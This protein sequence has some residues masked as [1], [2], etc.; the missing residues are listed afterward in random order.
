ME[1]VKGDYISVIDLGTGSIRNSIYDFQG[2]VVDYIR[3]DNPVVYPRP[4]WAEQ[5]TALWWKLITE[6]YHKIPET[7]RNNI[8]AITVTSQR[9]GIVAVNQAFEPLDNMIIWLDNRTEQEAQHI[10]ET[11]GRDAIYD[12]CGLIPHP[13][14]SLSKIQWLKNNKPHIYKQAFKLL[15]AEDYVVSRFANRAVTEFSIA[16]RTCMLDVKQKKW[17]E[18]ILN[19]FGVDADKLPELL[20]PGSLVGLIHE[21]A[22]RECQLPKETLIFTGAGD[23]QAAAIGSGAVFEGSVSIGIGTSSAL[24]FTIAEPI[25][26]KSKKIILNCAAIPGMWEYEPPIWNTGGLIKWYFDQVE[27]KTEAAYYDILESTRNIAP[28]ADG[29]IALPYFSGSGS[30]RWNPAQKGAFFGLTLAHQKIHLLKAL[31]ESVAFEIKLN[32]EAVKKSGVTINNIILSGGASQN[33]PLCQIIAD[34]LQTTVDISAEKEASSTGCFI[35]LKAAI[36]D[37]KNYKD[38]FHSLKSKKEV[39]NPNPDHAS[40]Y[41]KVYQSFIKLGDLFDQNQI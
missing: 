8:A 22:A 18:T 36:D 15:Q 25:P 7:L 5:N 19:T 30:P 37:N 4:G 24:S 1:K 34:V 10:E 23:Q 26:D 21:K 28:G 17:S 40:I 6:S 12:I 2:K 9:E 27:N 35:L 41:E 3:A 38:I 31:M 16:S 13:V 33:L 20:E 39:L 14:W 29:L 11:I 32:V